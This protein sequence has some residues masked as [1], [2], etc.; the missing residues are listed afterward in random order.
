MI[1]QDQ[2]PEFIA[3]LGQVREQIAQANRPTGPTV[4]DLIVG[5]DEKVQAVSSGALPDFFDVAGEARNEGKKL[6]IKGDLYRASELRIEL[7]KLITSPRN[8]NFARSFVNRVWKELIGRGIVEPVDDF[9]AENLP[10]HPE[11]LNY[12]A[13]EFVAGGYDLKN[14]LRLICS[15]QVYQRG[16]LYDVDEPTLNDAEAA[17]A[18][19][20]MRRMIAEVLFDS[21][22]QAGHLEDHKWPEGANLKT[23][24]TLQRIAIPR[25]DAAAPVASISETADQ[26]PK[27]MKQ[28]VAMAGGYDLER[29]IEVDFDK[30]LMKAAGAPALDAMRV[31]SKEEVEAMQMMK[32]NGGGDNGPRMRYVERYVDVEID[33]NPRFA[34]A[35]RMAAPA[36]P[37]HFLRIFGQP[38]R[39]DLG[40]HREEEASMRQAL[41]MLNG[42]LT[43]EASRVGDLEPICAHLVGRKADLGDAIGMA[44]REILT[45]NPSP[46]ELDEA[47]Q[48][49]SAASSWREGMADLRWV[50]FNCHEFRFLP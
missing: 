49:V 13:R 25:D 37:S 21:I 9:T 39:Q 2:T 46:E 3:R 31:M 20:P 8:E 48:I 19:A 45:R 7:G 38:A 6:D 16:R 12:V 36:P 5:A 47:K 10:S 35:L 15:T 33:D 29:A 26:Q 14:L 27:M 11:T 41:M 24:R 34:S 44:Y 17:F 4:D 30:V 23:V 40:D 32:E 1:S 28:Q 18:S 50:L 43:H 22:V 42:S